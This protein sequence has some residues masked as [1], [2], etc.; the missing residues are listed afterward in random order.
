MLTDKTILIVEDDSQL[1]EVYTL[2]L[3]LEGYSVV[4]AENGQDALNKLLNLDDLLIPD[5]IV[6][7]LKMPT[8]TGNTFLKI[9]R[10][11]YKSRF[12]HVPVIV[13]SAHGDEVEPAHISFMLHKPVPLDLFVEKIENAII[14]S[15]LKRSAQFFQ[16][17]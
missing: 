17:H 12:D 9:I 11:N 7:D 6:L 15:E 4:E 13:C 3:E 2:A 14:G 10:T 8:M 16:D 1:R 5:C